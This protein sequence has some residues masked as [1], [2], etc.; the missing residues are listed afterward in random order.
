MNRKNIIVRILL[1]GLLL[2]TFSCQNGLPS[3]IPEKDPDLSQGKYEKH[4]S[5]LKDA[6][7]TNNNFDAA[8]QIA[9]LKGDKSSA[10]QLLRSSIDENPSSCLLYTSPSPRDATLSRMPSSA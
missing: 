4:V 9:N 5:L 8:L 6:Y 1:F 7:S 2:F 10:Y 3:P